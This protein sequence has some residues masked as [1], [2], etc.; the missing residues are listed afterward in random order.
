MHLI[1]NAELT[2][3]TGGANSK[4]ENAGIMGGLG[5]G[6]AASSIITEAGGLR[7]VAAAARIPVASAGGIG[8][9]AAYEAGHAV[10][11]GLYS[12]D[13][14]ALTLGDGIDWM[15]GSLDSK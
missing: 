7:M 1:N 6:V 14:F 12:I 3:I 2:A 15:M 9:F 13:A 5:G 10:G 11:T 4:V 8:L